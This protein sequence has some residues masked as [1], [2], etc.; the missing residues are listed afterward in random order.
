MLNDQLDIL[1][2]Q[3]K[4]IKKEIDGI[5]S[6]LDA[7]VIQ[8]RILAKQVKDQELLFNAGVISIVDYNQIRQQFAEITGQVGALTSSIAKLSNP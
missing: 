7:S 3:R 8:K 4:Q 1:S 5:Q 6:Q 2:Q